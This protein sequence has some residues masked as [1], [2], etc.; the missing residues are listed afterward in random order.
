MAVG[1]VRTRSPRTAGSS[2]RRAPG[3][4]HRARGLLVAAALTTVSALLLSGLPAVAAS[5]APIDLARYGTVVAS[6]TQSDADGTFP[7]DALIDGDAT[8]RWASG[9]GPD[10]DVPFTA[11]VTVDLG[12]VARVDSIGIDWEASYA[13][14]YRIE[15]TQG[16]PALEA[17]WTVAKTVTSDGGRDEEAVG[18]IDAPVEARYVRL[19]MLQRAAAT[20]DL[21]RQHWYG[22]SAFGL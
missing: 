8:T 12:G 3:S 16:D 11:S 21:P 2:S 13:T 14:S 18:T 4:R 7:A 17:S 9:N 5:A 15:T 1:P 22:Y 20:W 19:S 10:E 6:A